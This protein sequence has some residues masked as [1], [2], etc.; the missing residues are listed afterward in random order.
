MHIAL[1]RASD[2][3][4]S[5]GIAFDASLGSVQYVHK[6]GGVPPGGTPEE[7]GSQIA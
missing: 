7:Q 1:A 2:I 5:M 6:T 3:L 4:D